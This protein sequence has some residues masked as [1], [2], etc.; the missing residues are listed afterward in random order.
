[1]T[2]SCNRIPC[3]TSGADDRKEQHQ[4]DIDESLFPGHVLP[5][6][7][8]TTG[9]VPDCQ[10]KYGAGKSAECNHHQDIKCGHVLLPPLIRL[11]FFRYKS[12]SGLQPFIPAW[13]EKGSHGSSA[14]GISASGKPPERLMHRGP[15]ALRPAVPESSGAVPQRTERI[16]SG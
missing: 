12:L 14:T 9:Q 5:A 4:C 1:M 8:L 15:S 10:S 6:G 3:K 11:P 16:M 2:G 7:F 13:P